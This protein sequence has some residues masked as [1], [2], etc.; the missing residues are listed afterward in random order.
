[1]NFTEKS[2]GVLNK[3]NQSS[4]FKKRS[5]KTTFNKFREHKVKLL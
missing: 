1:M 3:T 5:R 4:F 2:L